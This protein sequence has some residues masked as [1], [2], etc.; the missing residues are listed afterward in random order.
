MRV[1]YG[2]QGTGNGHISRARDVIPALQ[3]HCELDILISGT[4]SE[5]NLPYPVTYRRKG[6]SFLYNKKGGLDY[7]RTFTHN[8]RLTLMREITGLPVKQYD[9]IIN[10]FEP[11]SAWAARWHGV[12][13]ISL[14]HQ[15]AF[16]SGHT[17][18]PEERDPLG[19]W[20]L[21]SY[22]PSDSGIGFHFKSYDS[23]IR[24]PV[25]RQAVREQTPTDGGYYTV[26]L[27]AFNET[28]L[29][30]LLHQFPGTEWQVFSRY[31]KAPFRDKNVWVH[32]VDSKAFTD[33]LVHCT[34]IFTGAG[35]ETPAEA[36]Y[37]GKKIFSVPIKGQ[38]EQYCNAAALA[39]M[40]VPVAHR[41]DETFPEKMTQWLATG[42]IAQVNYPDHINEVAD[43]IFAAFS[44]GIA[45]SPA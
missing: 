26:Y 45:L 38:Y 36:L 29:F 42:P 28:R 24:T 31:A 22:A 12:P 16:L 11:V 15:A 17:P 25:I 13:C 35:F 30:Q 21:R 23:F 9:L 33:S 32:P 43:E 34:G 37:L 41:I 40:G 8:F 20:I 2:I 19:E 44:G 5:V 3:R 10:D 18:R 6:A 27:P 7:F 14:G 1:L 39:E 4:Q